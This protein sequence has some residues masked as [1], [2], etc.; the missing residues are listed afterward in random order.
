MG[1]EIKVLDEWKIGEN[2]YKC[3]FCS[4]V[5]SKKGIGG[6]VYFKHT[7]KGQDIIHE[8]NMRASEERKGKPGHPMSFEARKKISE[9]M[10]KAH[11]E[12]RANNW[13]DSRR[14]NGKEGSY[15]EQFF[16]KVIEN[17]LEDKNYVY[18]YRVLKYSLDFAWPAKKLYIEIDGG[19]HK[20]TEEYDAI[21]D[22]A[23]NKEGW[24]GL[25]IPWIHFF[26]F[27]KEV[28]E[29]V[30]NFIDNG[31]IILNKFR[32]KE[33]NALKLSGKIKTV[34]RVYKFD[35][36]VSKEKCN[37]ANG[38][39]KSEKKLNK[40]QKIQSYKNEE[41]NKTYNYQMDGFYFL[42]EL[43]LETYR[44]KKEILEN[45]DI[46]FTKHGCFV[47]LGK[48]WGT[49]GQTAARY[50]KKYFKSYLEK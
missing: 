32:I 37:D 7:E 48:L 14:K 9:G 49:T 5:T 10:K 46:D 28:I 25:R 13:Q 11:A 35:K 44:R 47:K 12:G 38:I 8:I 6:H 26:H 50:M 29:N 33:T 45:C 3:P 18:Q 17:E 4:F 19:Q 31:S 21:R 34:K 15:P 30:K 42:Q 20:Y 43:E 40:K 16:M 23:L 1:K 22:D 24:I 39:K 41:L 2:Q 27:P 36:K